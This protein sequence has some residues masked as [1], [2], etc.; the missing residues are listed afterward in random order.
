M[1]DNK[2]LFTGDPQLFFNRILY[3]FSL[4]QPGNLHTFKYGFF[5]KTLRGTD[6]IA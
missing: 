3:F 1:V 2:L 4:L 6:F 5:F